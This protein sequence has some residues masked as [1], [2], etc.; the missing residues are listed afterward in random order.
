MTNPAESPRPA[1]ESALAEGCI[2]AKPTSCFISANTKDL[3]KNVD[4]DS[5]IAPATNALPRLKSATLFSLPNHRTCGQP[6]HWTEAEEK[7]LAVVVVTCGEKNWDMVATM[8]PNRSK[9][10]CRRKWILTANG[11]TPNEDMPLREAVA[12][13]GEGN[14]DEIAARMLGHTALACQVRWAIIT[15]NHNNGSTKQPAKPLPWSDEEEK[16]LVHAI[17]TCGIEAW[18]AVDALVMGRSGVACR[19]KWRMMMGTWSLEEDLELRR[20]KLEG[21]CKCGSTT[22]N[23]QAMLL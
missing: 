6:F 9:A 1:T 18:A 11:W 22:A 5:P 2:I 8:M 17:F 19:E 7:R 4:S 14:W 3:T 10:A 13:C 12:A 21:Y 16:R 23:N 20:R 15:E